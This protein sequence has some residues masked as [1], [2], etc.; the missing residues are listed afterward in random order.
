MKFSAEKLNMK[1]LTRRWVV[2]VLSVVFA[3]PA[4]FTVTASGVLYQ[5]Y[6]DTA[7]EYVEYQLVTVRDSFAGFSAAGAA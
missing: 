1:G 2:N 4:I 3:V 7:E 5:Y 6:F